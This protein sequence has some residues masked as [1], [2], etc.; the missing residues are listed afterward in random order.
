MPRI[1]KAQVKKALQAD[2]D[3]AWKQSKDRIDSMQEQKS[4]PQVALMIEKNKGY[5][6][7]LSDVTEILYS[8]RIF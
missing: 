7:A 2:L 8:R 4:N 3:F 5:M 6:M 1:T